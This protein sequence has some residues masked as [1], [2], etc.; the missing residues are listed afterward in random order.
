[1]PCCQAGIP[2][3]A[4]GGQ[5][6]DGTTGSLLQALLQSSH[7]YAEAKHAFQKHGVLVEGVAVDLA[8]MQRQK[9]SAVDGLTKGIEGLFKKN[10]ARKQ[11]VARTAWILP[12][13]LHQLQPLSARLRAQ[14]YTRLGPALHCRSSTCRGGASCAAPPK[15]RCLLQTARPLRWRRK[16]LSLRLDRR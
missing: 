14:L 10:K 1:M 7:M 5:V 9:A 3:I 15:W 6:T 2:P 4:C 11:R 8:A 16:T 12:Q 13:F